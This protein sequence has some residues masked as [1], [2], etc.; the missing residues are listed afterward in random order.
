[1]NV[2]QFNPPARAR[3][4]T[5][6]QP[7]SPATDALDAPATATVLRV[8]FRGGAAARKLQRSSHGGVASRP[9]SCTQLDYTGVDDGRYQLLERV[10]E[11]GVQRL[12]AATQG[13]VPRARSSEASTGP[14]KPRATV[15]A[16]ITAINLVLE[17]RPGLRRLLEQ[18]GFSLFA[19]Y[20]G[21]SVALRYA[22]GLHWEPASVQDAAC[23]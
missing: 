21:G 13:A 11:E 7:L 22:G 8:D 14:L 10:L 2:Y 12:I 15:A 6:V 4:G 19:L 9:C 16:P 17:R 1:M 5:D 18:G 23:A 3:Q 20:E